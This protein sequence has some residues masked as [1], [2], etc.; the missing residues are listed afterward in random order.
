LSALVGSL[1][2]VSGCWLGLDIDDPYYRPLGDMEVS[3]SIEGSQSPVLCDVFG[4]RIWVLEVDGPEHR[5]VVL[6][7]HGDFWSSENDLASLEVGHYRVQ[8]RA[9]D[10]HNQPRAQLEAEVHL[11]EGFRELN[12]NFLPQDFR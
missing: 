11:D 12:I 2:V 4:V 8:V 6:R 9:E 3:W 10:E 1:F 7:C 5:S